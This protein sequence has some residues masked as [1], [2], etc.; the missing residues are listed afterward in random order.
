MRFNMQLIFRGFFTFALFQLFFLHT[1]SWAKSGGHYQ[2]S[3]FNDIAKVIEQNIRQFGPENVLLALDIDNTTLVTESDLGSEH[4]FLWQSQLIQEKKTTEA[5]AKTLPEVLEL[6]TR[7]L[8]LAK[9]RP[10]EHRIPLDLT[11]WGGQGVK[12]LALTSRGVYNHDATLR[13]LKRSGFPYAKYSPGT[14]GSQSEHFVPYDL[15]NPEKSGLTQ[16]DV[17]N[18]KLGQPSDVFW[19]KGVFLTEGQHKG[20]MLR[21]LLHRLKK[22]FKVIIFIDDRLKH[23]EGLQ[24]AFSNLSTE[25]TTI[26]YTH[27]AEKILEF[28]QSDKAQVKSDWCEFA[29]ALK[30]V[31]NVGKQPSCLGYDEGWYPG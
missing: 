1:S 28:N 15:T 30:A 23:S 19:D 2:L 8:S 21:T 31:A 29:R 3:Q 26:Q 22:D 27:E 5:V 14:P 13:E 25:M 11:R 4:W 7:I 16:Q 10:V 17:I 6:Q 18:F 9:M 20:I 12:M 24:A